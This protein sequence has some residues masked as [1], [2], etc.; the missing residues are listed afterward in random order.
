M[1]VIQRIEPMI[2]EIE[3]S[4]KPMIIIGHQAMLRCLYGYFSNVS[5]DEI[6]Y[7]NLPLNQVIKFVPK[8][9]GF[10]E[11][12]FNIDPQ[13]KII[14]GINYNQNFEEGKNFLL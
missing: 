3:R 9:Y 6:P 13:T 4:K 1:D 14:S 10:I 5:L 8:E 11:E 7:L 2:Y 12:K